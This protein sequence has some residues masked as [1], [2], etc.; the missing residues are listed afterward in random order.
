MVKILGISAGIIFIL[1]LV[2]LIVGTCIILFGTLMLNEEVK[3]EHAKLM[4]ESQEFL[5]LRNPHGG[6]RDL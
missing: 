3:A 5:E 1:A 6:N 4:K 2:G